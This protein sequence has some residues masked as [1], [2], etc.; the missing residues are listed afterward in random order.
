M[1][2]EDD[3]LRA[4]RAARGAARRASPFGVRSG[5]CTGEVVAAANPPVI[6]E[7]VA[8]AERL[9]RA[10]ARGEI[11]LAAS[12]WQVVRHAAGASAARGRRLPARGLDAGAPAIARRLDQPLIGR[13]QEVGACATRSRASRASA[14][15]SC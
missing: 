13:E 9:A 14:R 3:A 4:L 10:A 2:H 1:A 5:A 7:A 8:V 15:R 11:R 6:G 12:T